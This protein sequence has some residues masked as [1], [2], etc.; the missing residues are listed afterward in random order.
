MAVLLDPFHGRAGISFVTTGVTTAYPDPQHFD[1][2]LSRGTPGMFAVRLQ[3]GDEVKWVAQ[4]ESDV[5]EIRS[6]AQDYLGHHTL[7][8]VSE[9]G[10]YKLPPMAT[11]TVEEVKEPGEWTVHDGVVGARRLFVVSVLYE[12][13]P[14]QIV[15]KV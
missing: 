3:N 14:E 13:E 6:A 5:V 12:V 1:T 15:F 8:Q 10:G 7:I 11:V 2:A 9:K 4:E